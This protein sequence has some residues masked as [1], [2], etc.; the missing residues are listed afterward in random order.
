MTPEQ[1]RL[2]LESWA[3]LGGRADELLVRFYE[4]LFALD[5]SA[6]ALFSHTNMAVQRMKF[7][8]MIEAILA[9]REEPRQFVS[10]AAALGRRHRD[11]GVTPAQYDS[12]GVALIAALKDLAGPALTP[13]LK[14]S[15]VAGYKLVAAIMIRAAERPRPGQSGRVAHA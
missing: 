13:E 5:P 15:W 1:V 2:I 8:G 6:H 11:Y 12:A 7:A 3:K 14:E 10:S 9:L 4:R